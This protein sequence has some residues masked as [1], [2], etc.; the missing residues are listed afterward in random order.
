[1]DQLLIAYGQRPRVCVIEGCDARHYARGWCRPHYAK[2]YRAGL[3]PLVHES[4]EARFERLHEKRGDGCWHWTGTLSAA[5]YGVLDAQ[6]HWIA[7]RWAYEHFVGP[8]PD[9][10]D[11]DHTCHNPAL[12]CPGGAECLHRRCVNPAHLEPV[13][14]REN[15]ARSRHTPAGRPPST[16]C[17]KG[18]PLEGDNLY[19]DSDG[20]RRCRACT[21][22]WGKNG[23]DRRAAARA[24]L[25]LPI[26][27]CGRTCK[28]LYSTQCHQCGCRAA[29]E[30]RRVANE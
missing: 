24:E 13:T 10:L 30:R 1:M 19:F 28:A 22:A 23:R 17:A 5:G 26:C 29:A 11:L 9:G 7:H 6:G 14:R 21:R 2:N 15:L 8:I 4:A 18:H 27:E 12:D 16:E 3:S 20:R 25:P